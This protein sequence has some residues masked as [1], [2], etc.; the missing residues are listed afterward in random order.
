M[1]RVGG[2]GVAPRKLLP[3][4][5]GLRPLVL[6]FVQLLQVRQR[7]LIVRI[8]AQAFA[9]RLERPVDEPALLV[10][11]A[12]AEQDVGVL[13][14]A[15]IR[16]LQQLLML[17]DGAADL[18]LLAIEVPEDQMDL[19]RIAGGS[20]GP[21]Q[22]VDGRICLIGREKIEAEHVVRRLA[23]APAV[24]PLAVA[25]LVALPRLAH[26]QADE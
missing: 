21:C 22:L 2:V 12:E 11:E 16:A 3:R 1:P 6:L 7:V 25:K 26:C 5:I 8:E 15:Q 10:V 9:E 14:L 13:Q 20:S 18:S 17:L 24:D 4:R 23:R 19:E